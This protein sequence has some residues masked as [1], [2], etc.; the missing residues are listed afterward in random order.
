MKNKYHIKNNIIVIFLFNGETTKVSKRHME[1]LRNFRGRWTLD[2]DYRTGVP[3]VKSQIMVKGVTT[4]TILT[5]FLLEPPDDKVVD[6]INGDT[7]DNTDENLRVVPHAV[8]AQN[9]EMLNSD[10]QTGIRGIRL[11]R[12]GNYRP[13]PMINGKRYSLP[14]KK[15]IEEAVEDLKAFYIKMGVPY[16]ERGL[17]DGSKKTTV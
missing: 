17:E 11:N 12:H 10:S 14:S 3:Y 5:R 1:K 6:H 4:T 13:V 2:H 9:R 7:L 16:R 15:T 8:N